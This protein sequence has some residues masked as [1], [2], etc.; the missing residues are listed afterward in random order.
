MRRTWLCFL[1]V[2]I[3]ACRPSLGTPAS[4]ITKV[5]ILAI[6]GEPPEARPG[7]SVAFDALVASPTGTVTS[8]PLAWAFCTA[9][10]S[11]TQDNVVSDACLGDAALQGLPPPSPM[12]HA[13]TPANGCSLFGPDVP[14]VAAGS[15]P[16][17]PRDPDL[18]GGYYQPVRIELGDVLG[19]GLQR[20]LCN[21]ANA[22]ASIAIDYKSRYVANKNPVLTSLTASV[23]GQVIALD[24][25]PVKAHVRLQTGWTAESVEMYVRWDPV[26]QALVEHPESMRASWF[27][28]AGSL[29]S[30]RTG[31]VEGDGALVT[32]DDWEAPATSGIVYL[33]LVLRDS[34]GGVNFASYELHVVQS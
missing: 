7:A 3:V 22:P 34:R 25:I 8:A 6:R 21:L 24:H 13:P 27:V 28:T 19:F 5:Q 26:T 9:P 31:N 12:A 1:A 10:K 15:P 18:T 14:P 33:W 2:F 4:L 20:I 17:R 11:P 32:T 16:L 23:A 30:D 29:S